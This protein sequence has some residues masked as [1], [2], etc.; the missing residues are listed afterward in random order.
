M[1]AE[2]EKSLFRDLAQ[3]IEQGKSEVS[4]QVNSTLTV[5]YWQV[6]HKINKYML[7]HKRAAYAQ[8]IVPALSVQLVKQFGRSFHEKNL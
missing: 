3:I 7:D 8:E 5:V 2:L 1:G 4:R 6:G